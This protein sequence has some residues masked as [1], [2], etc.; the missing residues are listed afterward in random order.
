MLYI[1]KQSASS[2]AY[3]LALQRKKFVILKI[4]RLHCSLQPASQYHLKGR[5]VFRSRRK[6]KEKNA[7]NIL[8]GLR[9]L[10]GQFG[11]LISTLCLKSQGCHLI[12]LS[13]L[14]SCFSAQ[15]F[16][17]VS[18]FFLLMVHPYFFQKIL[19]HLFSRLFCMALVEQLGD[20]WQVYMQLAAIMQFNFG[21]VSVH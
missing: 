2:S 7:F 4:D 16:C 3:S 15:S 12:P 10:D 5:V 9:T 14:L 13:Y 11:C 8:V 18:S 19:K 1:V 20:S 6:E 21:G 17:S